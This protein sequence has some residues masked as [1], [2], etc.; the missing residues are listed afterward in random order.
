M[1]HLPN[2]DRRARAEQAR[3][4]K[5][6]VAG[7]ERAA[8]GVIGIDAGAHILRPP[9][10]LYWAGLRT[11]GILRYGGSYEAYAGSLDEHHWLDWTLLRSDDGEL[12][13]ESPR[14]WHGGLPSAPPD[15]LES[16][17]FKLSRDEADYLSERIVTARRD[18]LF[19]AFVTSSADVSRLS[20][21]WQ[22]PERD[23]LPPRLREDLAEAER[24]SLVSNGAYLLYNLML[25]EAS[26]AAGMAARERQLDEYRNRFPGWADTMTAQGELLQGAR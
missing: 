15:F 11:L 8:A 6:L 9:S 13:E 20:G 18:T 1:C 14:A 10:I 19:A 23:N 17:T 2:F 3:L 21:P 25:A 12:I 24:F 5:A 4:V 7:G 16:T 22:H 26:V